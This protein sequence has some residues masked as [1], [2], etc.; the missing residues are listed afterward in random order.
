MPVRKW[1][2]PGYRLLVVFYA[3]TLVL[4][5]LLG[6]MGWQLVGQDRQL[7]RQRLEERREH[8]ADLAATTLK[9]H[10]QKT[11]A[12]LA[13]L[14]AADTSAADLLVKRTGA[15]LPDDS[16]LLLFSAGHVEAFPAGRLL[17]FPDAPEAPADVPAVCAPADAL[18]IQKEDYGAAIVALIPLVHHADPA[19][20]A[21]ALNRTA[22]CLKKAG[23]TGE[24]FST[25]QD[26]ER[27]GTV[28][29]A[30]LPVELIARE[31][32]LLIR[33]GEE[34]KEALPEARALATAL[35]SGRWRIRRASFE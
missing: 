3:T 33:E 15:T 24:A 1:L 35:C 10:L 26:L 34:S 11:G 14:A 29:V 7:A 12:R 27:M 20:R 31:A 9:E 17:F 21:E 23:R 8:A 18:E 32:R 16:A 4:V 19:I 22:R 2:Q 6:W 28:T 13:Q 5:C 25:Y 30:G